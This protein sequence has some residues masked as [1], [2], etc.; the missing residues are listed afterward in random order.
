MVSQIRF[1]LIKTTH[2][3][4]IGAAARALKTMGQ[5]SMYLVAPQCDPFCDEA[6]A[7]AKG[8]LNLLQ[9]AV[10]TDT[11]AQALGDCHL[12]IGTASE[13][14][15]FDIPLV[16]PRQWLDNLDSLTTSSHKIAILFGPESHGLSNYELQQ[17][18]YHWQIPTAHEYGSLNLASAV[19]IVAYEWLQ[20]ENTSDITSNNHVTGEQH[21]LTWQ[22]RQKG[23]EQI[24]AWLK[25]HPFYT[26]QPTT[27]KQRLQT[28]FNRALIS[29]NDM[30]FIMG[31]ARA[32]REQ[33]EAN[34]N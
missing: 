32:L 34:V 27:F 7:R 28:I 21:L 17:C 31:L 33:G 10:V 25:T 11:L 2:P 3:G 4:N 15:H 13:Q 23:Y 30:N 1:I 26:R 16:S 29:Q 22:A 14:R 5:D 19:Q 8:G 9:N 20:A 18:H 12:V 6:L 24:E